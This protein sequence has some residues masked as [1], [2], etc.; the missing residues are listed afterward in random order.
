MLAV[1]VSAT[2]CGGI[3]VLDDDG[4]GGDGASTRATAT[5]ARG[6]A[7]ITS[8]I[9]AG[10]AT[11]GT[12]TIM[13]SVQDVRLLGSCKIPYADDPVQGEIDI[14]YENIGGGTGQIG[15]GSVQLL[16]A[17]DFEGW[18]FS[19]DV[20]PRSSG[21]VTAGSPIVV[22]HEKVPTAGDNSFLC[23]LC[24]TPGSLVV[25]YDDGE[26]EARSDFALSCAF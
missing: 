23:S 17:N 15:I 8:A 25:R 22:T 24:G 6:S 26:A 3:A 19:I 14:R 1:G 2:A 20:T 9:S 10:T 16:F 18:S 7:G 13:A 12:P 5:A 4:A 11:G 21:P